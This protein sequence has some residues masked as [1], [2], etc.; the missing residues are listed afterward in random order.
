MIF[1]AIRAGSALTARSRAT[2]N[3]LLAGSSDRTGQSVTSDAYLSAV[4]ERPEGREVGRFPWLPAWLSLAL[5]TRHLGAMVLVLSTAR[6]VREDGLRQV[7][8]GSRLALGLDQAQRD[9][10]ALTPVQRYGIRVEIIVTRM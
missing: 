9:P 2:R 10:F 3:A 1:R 8:A 4:R 6:T 7:R 5:G